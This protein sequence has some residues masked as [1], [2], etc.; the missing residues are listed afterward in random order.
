MYGESFLIDLLSSNEMRIRL[1]PSLAVNAVSLRGY[2]WC[3]L[4]VYSTTSALD[5]LGSNLEVPEFS[6]YSV[7]LHKLFWNRPLGIGIAATS[8]V[9][10]DEVCAKQ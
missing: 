10:C 8:A 7:L 1:V 5:A 9:I 3:S 6:L 2:L 4:M